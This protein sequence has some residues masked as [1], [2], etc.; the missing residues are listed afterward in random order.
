MKHDS[1]DSDGDD[2][3][4]RNPQRQA[5]KLV[6]HDDQLSDSDHEDS[7]RD[8]TSHKVRSPT[9]NQPQWCGRAFDLGDRLCASIEENTLSCAGDVP[10]EFLLN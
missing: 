6:A 7:R 3:D 5:D 2:A 10:P 8:E 4:V 1:D 9:W